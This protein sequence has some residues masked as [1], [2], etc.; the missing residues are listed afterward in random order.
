MAGEAEFLSGIYLYPGGA[1]GGDTVFS[2]GF[3]DGTVALVD[4]LQRNRSLAQSVTIRK[5]KCRPLGP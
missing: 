4:C 1:A 2:R 3:M 5:D